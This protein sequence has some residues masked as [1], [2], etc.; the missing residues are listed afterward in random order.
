MVTKITEKL[1]AL[2]TFNWT[3]LLSAKLTRVLIVETSR[4]ETLNSGFSLSTHFRSGPVA[5]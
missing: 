4:V 5:C 2:N 1:K 3:M